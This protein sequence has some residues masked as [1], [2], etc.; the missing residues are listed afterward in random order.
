MKKIFL[1]VL[2]VLVLVVVSAI[3][4][5]KFALPNVGDTPDITIEASPERIARGYYISNHVALC[6]DCHSRRDWGIYAAPPIPGT[7]GTGGGKV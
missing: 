7:A 2:L 4:Y 6:M 5:I 1:G 3:L